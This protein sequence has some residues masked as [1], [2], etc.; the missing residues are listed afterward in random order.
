MVEVALFHTVGGKIGDGSVGTFEVGRVVVVLL[1][2]VAA[3]VV[4]QAST[5]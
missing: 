1:L 5:T 2:G 4:F 3:L